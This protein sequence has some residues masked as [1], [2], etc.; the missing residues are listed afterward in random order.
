MTIAA[1]VFPSLN[2]AHEDAARKRV[3]RGLEKLRARFLKRG[4]TLTATVIAGAVANNAI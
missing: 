4:V 1:F 2:A 3:T